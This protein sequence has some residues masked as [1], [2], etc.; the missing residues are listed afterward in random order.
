MKIFDYSVDK[1]VASIAT[2]GEK[3]DLTTG[4]AKVAQTIQKKSY[5]YYP[6]GKNNKAPNQMVELVRS[7]GDISNLLET[8]IDFLIGSGLGLFYKEGGENK[9]VPFESY[10][11]YW[12]A[13]DIDGLVEALMTDIVFVGAGYV[14]ITSDGKNLEF[15]HKDALT[16]RAVKASDDESSI[17]G[18]LLSSKWESG[19]AKKAGFIPTFDPKNPHQHSIS[20]YPVRKHQTGQFYYNIPGWWSLETWIKIANRIAG[21][22]DAELDSEGNIGQIIR[23]SDKYFDDLER[24]QINNPDTN[25]PYTREELIDIF[26][27]TSEEFLF[28]VGKNK[29]LFDYCAVDEKGNLKKNIEIEAV[30]RTI[31]G[32]ENNEIY[33]GVLTAIS[34]S[35]QVLGSLSGI[36]DGKMNSGGGTEIRESANFQQYYRTPRERKLITKFFNRFVFPELK[37]VKSDIPDNAFFSFKNIVIETLDKNPT[38]AKTVKTNDY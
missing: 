25:Q 31:T 29:V 7:N 33:Q 15:S 27:D 34:N 36:S 38:S 10:K 5:E 26:K 13:S 28:G 4:S 23:I 11:D 3:V 2:P 6:F 9:E 12:F 30:K 20:I 24:Q 21:R 8:R 14:I 32:K 35:S 1:R 22:I 19:A 16:V 17:P 37:K 18:Y